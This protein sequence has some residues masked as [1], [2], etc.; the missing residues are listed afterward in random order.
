MSGV[1]GVML[2]KKTYLLTRFF[3]AVG[4]MAMLSSQAQDLSLNPVPSKAHWEDIVVD[5]LQF[6]PDLNPRSLVGYLREQFP[7]VQ[8][9]TAGPIDKLKVDL[10]LRSV[11]LTEWGSGLV[12]RTVPVRPLA[13]AMRM[14]GCSDAVG[15][16]L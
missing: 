6:G 10:E 9:V 16:P 13:I 1:I 14:W 4:L 2:M 3:V 12:D 7:G 5:E 8:L 11:G 15:F